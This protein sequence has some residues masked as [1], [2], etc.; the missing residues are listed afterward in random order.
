VAFEARQATVVLF[1]DQAAG[2]QGLTIRQVV[3]DRTADT[4]ESE[5]VVCL[6]NR[7]LC[8]TRLGTPSG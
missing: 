5:A 4:G 6:V 1:G 7:D 2:G 3:D 8:P